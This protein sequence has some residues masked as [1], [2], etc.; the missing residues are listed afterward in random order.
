MK[1]ISS[2]FTG[3]YG[4]NSGLLSPVTV[5]S[6]FHFGITGNRGLHFGFPVRI[7][8]KRLISSGFTGSWLTFRLLLPGYSFKKQ[9]SSW[10]YG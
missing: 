7:T 2:D 6:R 8:R 10:H 1:Q 3:N 4:D 9:I 5:K